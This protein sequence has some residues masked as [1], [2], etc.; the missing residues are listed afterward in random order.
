MQNFKIT[1]KH[2][3]GRTT[4][5]TSA[6]DE[7]S[8][9]AKVCA[10]EGCPESAIIKVVRIYPKIRTID[11]HAKEWFDKLYGNSYFSGHV[12]VNYGMPDAF[13]IDFPFQYGSGDHY[14]TVA[15]KLVRAI[16]PKLPKYDYE[17]RSSGIPIRAFKQTNCRKKDLM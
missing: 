9:R 8:A 15:M 17:A 14:V 13:Y 11:I 2:D 12:T 10:A 6:H 7:K 16:Y 1:V 3:A 4:I 5:K